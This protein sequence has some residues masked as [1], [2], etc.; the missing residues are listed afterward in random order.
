[1]CSARNRNRISTFAGRASFRPPRQGL[2]RGEVEII[3]PILT[4]L[5]KNIDIVKKRAYLSQF[6]VKVEIPS[7]YL[8]DSEI[9]LLH[10]QYL[11]LV[12]KFKTV[13]KEREIGKKNVETAAELAT[14]LQ[15]MAKEKEIKVIRFKKIYLLI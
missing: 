11:S 5:L 4:W 9:S 7:E 12:D 15:A 8:G 6:L 1:M 13:H 2:V 3:H 10:E 14:D